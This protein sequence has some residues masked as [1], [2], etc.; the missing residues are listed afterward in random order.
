MTKST[1]ALSKYKVTKYEKI[2]EESYVRMSDGSEVK[3]LQTKAEKNNFNGY[4]FLLI[5]GWATTVPGWDEML[6]EASKDF[7]ILYI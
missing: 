4:T 1:N 3:T 6:M 2:A 5:P 7:N